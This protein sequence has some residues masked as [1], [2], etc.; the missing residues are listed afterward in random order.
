V[1]LEKLIVIVV[2]LQV[3]LC[4]FLEE[5]ESA[6]NPFIWKMSMMGQWNGRLKFMKEFNYFFG[7]L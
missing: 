2:A 3:E 1:D 4:I 6:M 5:S 7:F